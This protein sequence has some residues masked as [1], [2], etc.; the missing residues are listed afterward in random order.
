M[1]SAWVV[2]HRAPIAQYPRLGPVGSCSPEGKRGEDCSI[3]CLE[4]CNPS[5]NSPILVGVKCHLPTLPMFRVGAKK[6]RKLSGQKQQRAMAWCVLL[7]LYWVYM[8]VS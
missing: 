1:Y 6:I 7:D 3:K 5:R 8:E 2:A 4:S